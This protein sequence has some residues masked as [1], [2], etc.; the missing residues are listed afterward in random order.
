MLGPV[1][2]HVAATTPATGWIPAAKPASV[3][4]YL[5]A[6]A[7]NSLVLAKKI[8]DL[9]PPPVHLP[10]MLPGFRP[11]PPRRGHRHRAA[12]LHLP[13]QPVRA[14]RPVPDEGPDREIPG[15]RRHPRG[16][17][18]LAGKDHGADQVSGP[19]HD[20]HGPARQAAPGAADPLPAGPPFAPAA[21][22]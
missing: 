18:R 17:V 9:A 14:G 19:V 15:K 20:R 8:P 12:S 5:V 10:V 4:S 1:D 11:V 22:R 7:R 2:N 6:T 13:G 16:A 3:L 21:F